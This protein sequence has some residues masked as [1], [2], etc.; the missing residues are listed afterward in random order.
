MILDCSGSNLRRNKA[1]TF[2][3][4]SV[5]SLAFENCIPRGIDCKQSLLLTCL[6]QKER[7]KKDEAQWA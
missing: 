5:V 1:I 3:N 7:E 4:I 6:A 2:H